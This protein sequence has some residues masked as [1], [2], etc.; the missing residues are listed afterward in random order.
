MGGDPKV[1]CKAFLSAPAKGSW[2]NAAIVLSRSKQRVS[3]WWNA[4]EDLKWFRTSGMVVG[5]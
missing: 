3:R 5:T 2:R 1:G 4:L